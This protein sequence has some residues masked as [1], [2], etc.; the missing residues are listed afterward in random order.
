MPPPLR[1]TTVVLPSGPSVTGEVA[2][3]TKP[4]LTLSGPAKVLAPLKI[5]VPEPILV[6]ISVLA[7]F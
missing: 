1:L 2:N 5:C 7:V 6:T 3:A 4:P